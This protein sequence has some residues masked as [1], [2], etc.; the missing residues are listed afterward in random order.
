MLE[1]FKAVGDYVKVDLNKASI[2]DL[3][4]KLHYR[5]TFV[6][7]MVSTI[8]VTQRQYIGEHIKCISDTGVPE[9]VINTFC[10]FSSTFTVVKHYNESL[11]AQGIIP[12]PGVGHFVEEEDDVTYHAY[13]QWVPFILFGQALMFYIPHYIWSKKEGGRLGA[14][15]QGL[16]LVY[17]ST[18]EEDQGENDN[19]ILSESHVNENINRIKT[20]FSNRLRA[21]S[22]W[23]YWLVVCEVLNLFNLLLQIYFTDLFL[24]GAFVGIG[25]GVWNTLNW[26]SYLDP[27]DI[28]FPKATKCIFHKYGPSGSL[29]NHDALCVMALNVI[30][31]KIYTILWFWYTILL[32]STVFGL[33]NR[34]M[35]FIL[36]S[37]SVKFN[38]YMFAFAC[39][40]KLN[41]KNMIT[42]TH[43]CYFGD[44]LFLY[45]LARNMNPYTFKMF[46]TSLAEDLDDQKINRKLRN[47]ENMESG[48]TN[49]STDDDRNDKIDDDKSVKFL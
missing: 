10:F 42:L 15:V 12:H 29:Q 23:S 9:N 27:L 36:H 11:I 1:P 19:V 28:I 2:D 40:G 37:R 4:F 46:F 44:W 6:L 35:I 26:N 33:L 49:N 18:Y 32:I 25:K 31:E 21:S 30:H 5:A 34:I 14:L 22:T 48:N 16:R 17:T 43:E 20:E 3:I 38:E 24:G 7:L 45:F 13:Y 41:L 39:P 47:M 8:L